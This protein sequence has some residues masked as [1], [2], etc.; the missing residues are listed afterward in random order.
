[1][2]VLGVDPGSIITGWGLLTG[3]A[4]K[5]TVVECGAIRLG[6]GGEFAA[7]LDRLYE[8]LSSV[9]TRLEPAVAA[10][11]KPYHGASARSSL[12]LAHA[13]GVVLAALAHSGV[14]VA[15]YAPAQVK[16]SVTGNGRA[17][18]SQVEAMVSRWL[19]AIDGGR[20]SDVY[21]ALAV[22]VCHLARANFDRAVRRSLR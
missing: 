20:P 5:P 15:E 21:D 17:E 10:V 2:R 8:E 9:A 18:K 22:A 6:R 16:L 19:G 11:E 14:R 4:S 3:H 12:Q 13:R 1:L 7:R